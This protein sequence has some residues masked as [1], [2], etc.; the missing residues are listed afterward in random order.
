[1][2]P[3]GEE[4]NEWPF[5]Q[6]LRGLCHDLVAYL[7]FNVQAPTLWGKCRNS[8]MSTRSCLGQEVQSSPGYPEQGQ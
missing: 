2:P 5:W 6:A 4:A 7:L 1:M 3:P 8:W